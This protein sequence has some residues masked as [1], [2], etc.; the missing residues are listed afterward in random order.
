FVN[1]PEAQVVSELDDPCT[2]C[3]FQAPSLR[4]LVETLETAL[5]SDSLSSG[6][7]ISNFSTQQETDTVL[8]SQVI[9]TGA[10]M[11]DQ[12][13]HVPALSENPELME[14]EAE[15]AGPPLV[16][17]DAPAQIPPPP[18]PEIELE[19]EGPVMADP[20]QE[21]L[22]DPQAV[23]LTETNPEPPFLAPNFLFFVLFILMFYILCTVCLL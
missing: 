8:G 5:V 1:I 17:G 21:L 3:V 2:L 7:T 23:P 10:E 22:L 16:L 18:P 20:D 4:S 19:L 6:S 12:G 11:E 13:H 14:E 9:V 15:A